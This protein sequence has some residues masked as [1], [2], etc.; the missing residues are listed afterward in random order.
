MKSRQK[1]S[2]SLHKKISTYRSINEIVLGVQIV[3]SEPK[4]TLVKALQGEKKFAGKFLLK[5]VFLSPHLSSS[6]PTTVNAA[7]AR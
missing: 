7:S 1:F 2:P 5:M 4:I 6:F 3:S